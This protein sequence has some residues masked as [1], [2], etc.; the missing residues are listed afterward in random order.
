MTKRTKKT[1]ADILRPI[2]VLLENQSK[3]FPLSNISCKD[4]TPMAK[5]INPMISTGSLTVFS[6]AI[7]FLKI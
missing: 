5:N 7:S 3:S 4:P 1:K 2:I 6:L